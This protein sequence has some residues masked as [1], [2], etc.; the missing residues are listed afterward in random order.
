ML[1]SSVPLTPAQAVRVHGWLNPSR[2]LDWATVRSRKDLDFCSL[3]SMMCGRVVNATSSLGS[4]A[5]DSLF[6]M[7]PSFK[8]WVSERKVSLVD[9]EVMHRRWTIRP[10]EDFG[11]G[12]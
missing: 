7:Q 2:R 3:Y 12:R 1:P 10:L 9:C 5:L 6:A 8:E 4:A 11:A